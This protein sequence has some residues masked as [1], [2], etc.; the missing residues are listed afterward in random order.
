MSAPGGTS[1]GTAFDGRLALLLAMAMFVLV[2]DTSIM[3]VSISAVV[4]DIDTTVSGIQSTIALEALVSAAFILIGSKV[5]DLIGRKR[6]YVIGL[7]CYASGAV[8]MVL[9][10]S[11]LPIIIFWAV[12]GG[13]GRLAAPPVDAIPHPR[14]LRGRGAGEGL[15]HGRRL[16][17]DRGSGRSADRRFHHD[18][19]VMEGAFAL[20][21]L[22]IA[23]VLSGIKLVKDV[24]YTGSRRVDVIGS[25][26]SV[27]GKGGIVI[28][29]LVWQEGGG[30][31]VGILLAVGV[32][33]LG[34]L[35]YWLVRRKRQGKRR[36]STP[37]TCS[38]R[39]CSGS[40]SRVS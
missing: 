17:G 40:V 3:N 27:L 26:F 8:A 15:R 14:E 18:L 6:A 19:P 11:L 38:A 23:I 28:G 21:A 9:A 13:A 12:I 16:G 37:P 36:C 10:H 20:E 24:P 39:N 7:L 35:A 30:G 32:F 5:G 31:A 1:E 22:I 25:L 4:E 34:A 2:V 29:I 33:G